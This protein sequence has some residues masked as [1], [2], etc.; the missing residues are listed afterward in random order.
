VDKTRRFVE[1]HLLP[2]G[3]H[4][5]AERFWREQGVLR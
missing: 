1:H 4:P 5:G 2:V 3:F